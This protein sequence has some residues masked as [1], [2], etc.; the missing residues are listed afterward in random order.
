MNPKTA[1]LSAYDKTGLADF[2]RALCE[3]GF[4]LVSTG[5]S[6]RTLREAGL[7]VLDVSELTGFPEMMDGRV[8]TLHPRV[9]GGILARRDNPE[10]LAT[11][12][13]HNIGL[14]DLVCVNLYPFAKVLADGAEESV[15]IENIDI[16]GPTL[17]R[18][19]A[20]NFKDVTVICDP[21]DYSRVLAMLHEERRCTDAGKEDTEGIYLRRELA[22]KVF[23]HTAA[24]DKM[25]AEWF[26]LSTSASITK[27]ISAAH[28]EHSFEDQGE[29]EEPGDFPAHIT[30]ELDRIAP[31]RYGENP[32]QNAAFYRLPGASDL[33]LVR[34]RQLH[35]KELSYNNLQDANAALELLHEFDTPCVLALKHMNPCGVGLADDPYEAWKK[36]YEAD[37][38]SIFGGIVASNRPITVPMAEEM[39]HI[40]LEIIIAPSFEKG[41]LDILEKKKNIRLL[42]LPMKDRDPLYASRL[43]SVIDGF[44]LQD[45]D[46]YKV[47]RE[48]C[49]TMGRFE[50]KEED[51]DDLL[52]AFSV[53]KHCK[54]NAIVLYK[55]GMTVGIGVGQSNR[56]GACRLAIE[57]AGEKARGAVLA[58]DAFF[59]MPDTLELAI[60]AGIRAVIQ[61]GGSIKDQ[62]SIDVCDKA[63]VPMVATGIRHFKH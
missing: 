47:S 19:A 12:K 32:H 54:S 45:R 41:A 57:Q 34:A 56:V 39:S 16:G 6:A 5:G 30:L 24:Y 38:V 48:E 31:L 25:I 55:D 29:D 43:V 13:A 52:N 7:E 9:H 28:V 59:P 33:S 60:A 51:W 4:R 10:D 26:S 14:I 42:E 27:P 63:E 35:G 1:L 22:G 15:M 61:P 3:L 37:P 8:K 58:S 62:D 46:L 21:G 23:A 40:F 50:P 11:L 17:L 49:R 44:L 18:A 20:K 2:G 36:A 53:V